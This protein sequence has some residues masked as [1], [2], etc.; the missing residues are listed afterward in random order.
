[1][2]SL[3]INGRDPIATYEYFS[4]DGETL[5]WMARYAVEDGGKEF[6]PWVKN[7]NGWSCKAFPKPWPLYGLQRL[8]SNPNAPIIIVEGEKKVDALMTTG[9]QYIPIAWPH[10]AQSAKKADWEPLA[11]R[12]VLLWPD[13]DDVGRKAMA[14]AAEVLLGLKCT[15]KVL[16][17]QGTDGWDAADAILKEGWD[18]GKIVSWAK[19]IV[20]TLEA[21]ADVPEPEPGPVSKV[22]TKAEIYASV[23]VEPEAPESLAPLST[24]QSW[25]AMG[26]SRNA[27]GEG[28]PHMNGVNVSRFLDYHRFA[29]HYDTFTGTYQTTID[30]G[31]NNNGRK[32]LWDPVRDSVYMR[33]WIQQQEGFEMA[34]R[35][36]IRDGF[37]KYC[38][39]H[40]YN[41]AQV[42]ME[43]LRW[44]GTPRLRDWIHRYMG[45]PQSRYHEDVGIMTLRSM[46][47]RVLKPGCQVHSMLTLVSKEGW[48]KSS[49]AR[50][51]GDPWYASIGTSWDKDRDMA[52]K[53]RGLLV[54]EI[55]ENESGSKSSVEAMKRMVSTA[56]DRVVEKYQNLP[57]DLVR[58]GIFIVTTNN[59]ELLDDN[60][61][62]RRYLPV[63]L[64]HEIDLKAL[65]AERDQLVAEAVMDVKAGKTW[66]TVEGAIEEAK[67][68]RV[69]DP[70]DE[71]VAKLV[72]GTGFAEGKT[73][74]S[75]IMGIMGIPYS[76]QTM[77]LKRR[78]G[79]S[80]R[81]AGCTTKIVRD[82]ERTYQ[83]FM[84]PYE[85]KMD[86]GKPTEI[87]W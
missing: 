76:Q 23:A 37:E 40:A 72:T 81:L 64:M 18:W 84:L 25:V 34:S 67:K 61:G 2:P 49:V 62:F 14:E 9:T 52:Q 50:I 86:D 85:R 71:P 55:A 41:E 5:G 45:V 78:I 57:T 12:A 56:I 30:W 70:M 3:R 6:R 53:I 60:T 29:A 10:G 4:L 27:N 36:A 21:P 83:A 46:V 17:V 43:D 15:V 74:I 33:H 73:T 1:M 32:R 35:E 82:G 11:G 38:M 31:A 7:G 42:W 59:G 16:Q 48:G 66:H 80:L 24:I 65:T 77:T 44:D 51:L 13:R 68:F 26:L 69:Q 63:V 20:K 75:E 39:D 28:K 54:A 58:S 22:L 19:G 8:K 47:A 87:S 79:A